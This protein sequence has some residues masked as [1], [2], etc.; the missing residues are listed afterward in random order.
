[1][2]GN[3][4]AEFTSYEEI[5]SVGLGVSMGGAVRA[6]SDLAGSEAPGFLDWMDLAVGHTWKKVTVDLA[7][8]SV[9]QD[10]LAG[11][12]SAHAKDIGALLRLTPY[13]SLARAAARTGF[14][15]TLR[16]RVDLGAGYA[17]QGYDGNSIVYIDPD[18]ADPLPRL[19]KQGVAFHL[20]ITPAVAVDE[21]RT[22]YWNLFSPLLSVG[23]ALEQSQPRWRGTDLGERIDRRGVEV[24]IAN[25]VT[26]RSGYIDDPTGAIQDN[27]SGWG[28]GLRYA[29]VAGVRYDRATV[30][31]SKYLEEEVEPHGLTAFLDPIALW[32]KLR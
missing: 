30:P 25:V 14:E 20:E 22:W 21:D 3:P 16:G 29:G 12:G 24:V 18:Q 23:G 17:E 6:L 31:Q 26:L 8:A 7:P 32:R 4:I 13:N 19:V 28:L 2:D 15:R 1:V 10:G 5:E 27:T 11:R 9:T